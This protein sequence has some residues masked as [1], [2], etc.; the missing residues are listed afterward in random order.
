VRAAKDSI[1][2]LGEELTQEEGEPA[3]QIAL[4]NPRFRLEYIPSLQLE[5]DGKTNIPGVGRTNL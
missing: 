5:T 4:G 2:R 1:G 3:S